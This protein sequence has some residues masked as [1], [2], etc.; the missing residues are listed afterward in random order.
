MTDLPISRPTKA[1]SVYDHLLKAII[2]GAYAIKSKLPSEDRLARDLGVSRPVL[3]T[4]LSRLRDDGIVVSQRGS[5]N[6]VARRPNQSVMKFVPLGS[7]TDIQRCYEFRMD[8]EAAAAKW[9]AKRRTDADLK[10]MELAYGEIDSSYM[11]HK[12]GVDADFKLHQAVAKA[13]QNS[14]YIIVLDSLAEQVGF[15]MN[16]SR[17]LTLISSPDRNALVQKEHREIIDAIRTQ[18][19]EAARQAMYMHLSNAWDRMFV[20]AEKP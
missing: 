13:S 5:G 6:F 19:A 15:G 12:L 18:D 16:L 7:I 11:D 4:A 17:S 10:A 14:N 9:A 2:E 8:L 1:D 3:R 20:G